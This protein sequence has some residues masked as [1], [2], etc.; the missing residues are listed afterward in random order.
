MPTEY[1]IQR[2]HPRYSCDVGVQI[3]SEKTQSG[4]WGA[5]A[6]ISL[7]GCYVNSFSP[8]PPDST[9][10]LRVKSSD[11]E[12]N[13]SGKVVTCHPGVGMGIQFSRFITR[14]D[15]ARLRGLVRALA[16]GA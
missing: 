12:I 13:I 9:V 4:N 2:K 16:M 3:R 8:L 1:A 14:D 10:I 7:G 5:L 15:E 6:D 11:A